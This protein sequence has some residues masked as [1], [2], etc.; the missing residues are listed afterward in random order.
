ML[1]YLVRDDAPEQLLP[2]CDLFHTFCFLRR[3]FRVW[4]DFTHMRE[5]RNKREQ[6]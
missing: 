2:W 6:L 4:R 3:L 1:N 5:N